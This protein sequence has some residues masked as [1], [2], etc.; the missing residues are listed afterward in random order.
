VYFGL[1]TGL[2][3][4]VALLAALTLLPELIIL[5]RPFGKET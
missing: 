4:F 5:A 3:M 1:L 2:A